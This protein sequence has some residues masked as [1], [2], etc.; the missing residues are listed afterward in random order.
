MAES[1]YVVEDE[2]GERIDKLLT[3]HFQS[4]SRTYFQELIE[5]GHVLV[6]GKQPKKRAQL[7]AGDKVTI[8]FA[9]PPKLN[10]EPEEIPLDILY[11]DEAIIAINKPKGMVV[12]PAPGVY[13]GT[14]ANALLFHCEGLEKKGFEE[15]RPGIVH[16]LDKDTTGVLIGAKTLEAHAKLSTLFS[17]RKVEKHY[18]TVCAGRPKEGTFVAPIRRHPV[19]RK[20]MYV[21]EAGKE[22]I[23]HFRLVAEKEDLSLVD[24]EL[25][26][27]RTHQIRVHL[28]AMNCPILGDQTYG[29]KSLNEKFKLE[30]Q[31]LHAHRTILPHPLTDTPLEIVAPLPRAMKNFI[32]VI[33]SHRL[34]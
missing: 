5:E 25:I 7:L 24:V 13:S 17:K 33:L 12:H 21:D 14:F 28:K 31:L 1:L 18:L 19:R 27:G 32:E 26:T 9:P 10:V 6:N 34:Q 2:V 20:E 4:H 3:R 22:A 8:T 15:H 11:E 23:S 16:R 30:S 29:S